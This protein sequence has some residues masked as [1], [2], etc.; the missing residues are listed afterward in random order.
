MKTSVMDTVQPD[1]GVTTSKESV[2]SVTI[3]VLPVPVETPIDVSIVQL[4]DGITKE[5]VLLTVH[6]TT[7]LLPIQ[8]SVT[9]VNPQWLNVLMTVLLYVLTVTIYI[10]VN[11]SKNVHM[12]CGIMMN[13]EN[14]LHVTTLV[15][16]VTKWVLPEIVILVKKVPTYISDIVENVQKDTT[17]MSLTESVENVLLNVLNVLLPLVVPN[18]HSVCS[19]TKMD[20]DVLDHVTKDTSDMNYNTNVLLVILG[21]KLVSN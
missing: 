4:E 11:V 3:L 12:E 14:V 16:L 21:V 5:D 15:K 8:E 20:A 9:N 7:M 17:E 18:V 13:S 2:L 6:N 19:C 10:T 1:I